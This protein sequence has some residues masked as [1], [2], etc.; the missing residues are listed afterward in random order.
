MSHPEE[1]A[2]AYWSAKNQ[3]ESGY[4][5]D[6]LSGAKGFYLPIIANSKTL[7]VLGIRRSRNFPLENSQLN[8]LRLVLTQLA[9][10]L[11]QTELKDEKEKIELEN[12][13]EK[14]RSNLLRAI[15]HDLR[16]PLTAISGIAETLLQTNNSLKEATRSK[17]LRDI[18]SESQ[19]LIRMVENLLSIT[20]INMDT[21][22]VKK[23]PEPIEEIIGAVYEHA[24]KVYPEKELIVQ[25]PESV[26]FVEVD[27]ILME[28]AIFNLVENA[29]RHGSD[30]EK[31]YLS[32]FQEGAKTV[33]EIKN[34]GE[35]SMKQFERIQ[36]N[37][38]SDNEVPVDS[39]NG[40]GIGLSIVKT[41]VH[42]HHGK[43]EMAVADG[44]T[45][46]RIYLN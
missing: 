15:S 21:M 42:A 8:Y 1:A 10:I 18:Q 7:A 37:L 29:F 35:I 4:G 41:I 9:V 6:T 11:E 14:V 16:T 43:L 23:T 25:L 38:S 30:S 20:R 46:V 32:V 36:S 40:L 33:C 27:P 34:T 24:K 28:Q 3:K 45:V 39:K 5:T 19:W 12:E 22:Q 44:Q 31:V 2:V 17:L 26:L 13:R